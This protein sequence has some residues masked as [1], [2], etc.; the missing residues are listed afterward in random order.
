M[1]TTERL[2]LRQLLLSDAQG[3]YTLRSDD[4]TNKYLDRQPSKTLEDATNFI[5]NI[6]EN[7]QRNDSVYWVVTLT[8]S[9]TFVGTICLFGFSDGHQTCEIG[10]ELLSDFQGKGIMQEAAKKVIEYAFQTLE[11][12][13]IEAFT[14]KNNQS[15]TKLLE[16]LEFTKAKEPTDETLDYSMFTLKKP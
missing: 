9:G 12:Q 10:Y 1:L 5:H 15:S 11:V 4:A 13:A 3:I 2:T 16:K 8:A 6:T 7:I 14:H